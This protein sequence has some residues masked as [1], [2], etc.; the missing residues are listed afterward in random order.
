MLASAF[1]T[2]HFNLNSFGLE[3]ELFA[4]K[5]TSLR[6]VNRSEAK[7]PGTKGRAGLREAYWNHIDEARKRLKLEHPD[8]SKTEILKMARDEFN[9]QF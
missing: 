4:L 2:V 6:L 8:L 3:C 5:L 7:K 9:P 1:E